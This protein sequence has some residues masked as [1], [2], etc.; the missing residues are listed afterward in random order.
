LEP[1]NRTEDPT[2]TDE[3][4]AL[5]ALLE[6][7]S[8]ADLLREMIGFTAHRLMELEVAGL[9]GAE[10]GERSPERSITATATASA[11]GRRAPAPSSCAF[12]SSGKAAISR[13]FSSRAGRP[14]RR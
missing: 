4:I 11:I 3:M 8:D 13:R 14:R 1:F 7:S 10:H 2:M 5:R 12:P 9:T 6:K